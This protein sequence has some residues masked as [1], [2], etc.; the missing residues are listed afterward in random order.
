MISIVIPAYNY[1]QFLPEAIESVLSQG[2]EDIE[3]LISD[4]ASTDNTPDV[5]A[6]YSARYPCIRGERNPV[7]LGAVPNFN[8]AVAHA[9]GEYVLVLG[10]DDLLEP[11]ALAALKATLDAHP[12]CGYVY[13]RYNVLGED[14]RMLALQHAGW[15]ADS[16]F[17]TR[18]EFAELLCHDCYINIV[19]TLFRRS[20]LDTRPAFFD[21][22]LQSLP[23]ERFFRATDWD[24]SLDLS[25]RNVRSAF[26]NR[27]ISVFR[28]HKAQA[29]GHDRYAVSGVAITEHLV[30][31]ERY[32]TEANLAR[33]VGRLPRIFELAYGKFGFYAEHGRP[34]AAG[35][36]ADIRARFLAFCL[37]FNHLLALDPVSAAA[38]PAGLRSVLDAAMSSQPAAEGPT[39][40]SLVPAADQA[41]LF[42]VI[43]TTYN[44]PRL[45]QDALASVLDQSCQDFEILVVNDG[46]P[47]VEDSLGWTG[48]D[49]RITYIRQPN[50][51]PSAARN[52]ALRLARGRYVVYLDDDDLMRREHLDILRGQLAVTPDSVV[53]TSAE[54]VPEELRGGLRVE[55]KRYSPYQHED[56]DYNRLQVSNY[57]PINTFCHPRALLEKTGLFDETLHAL[58]D[59]DL[60][61]RFSR[62]CP[63]VH[64]RRTTV[65]VRQRPSDTS[66]HQTGRQIDT[67]HDLFRLIYDRYDDQGNITVRGGRAVVLAADHPSRARLG[68]FEYQ[69]W[70]DAH[71]LREVDVE[72][73][74]ERMISKWHRRPVF[75]LIVRAHREHMD[76]LG[77]TVQS[78]QQQFYTHWRL[79]VVADQPAP[80]PVFGSSDLLGWVQ[81]ESLE[82]DEQVAAA[83]NSVVTDRPGDWV[84]LLPPG[85][86]LSPECLLRLGDA[87]QGKDQLA[88]I[89]TDHDLVAMPGSYLDPWFKPDFNLEYLMSWDYIDAACFFNQQMIMNLGGFAAFPGKEGY[90]LLLRMADRYGESAISHLAYPMVHLPRQQETK[91]SLTAQRVAIEQHLVRIGRQGR[92]FDGAKPGLFKVEYPIAGQP[93]VSVIV[94]N[95]DRL[96]FLQPCLEGLLGRTAY[97]NL[98]VL[99]VDNQSTD[100]DVL[101]YYAALQQAYPDQIR[102]L[103]YDAPFNFSAQCN[104]GASQA[105]GEYLLFLNNDIEIVQP[106]W[107]ERLLMHAQRPEVG[108]VGAKLVYPET[109]KVQHGGI[110]LGNSNLLMGVANHFGM[111]CKLDDPGYMNR[112]QCDLYLSAVTAACMMMRKDVF[113]EAGG[114]N[115]ELKVLFNDVDFCLRV[116]QK[117]YKLLWTPYAILVHHHGISV[118]ARLSDPVEQGRF[119]ERSRQEH[120]YMYEHWLTQLAHDPAYN[121]NLA[122]RGMPLSYDSIVPCSWEPT[123]DDRP[124]IMGC[125]VQ[126]GSG[127]YRVLQPLIALAVAGKAQETSVHMEAS[128]NQFPSLLEIERTRPNVLVAQNAFNDVQIEALKYY[129]QYFPDM[130]RVLTLDDLLTDLPEK[131]SLYRHIKAHFRDGRRRL[132]AS[133]EHVDR[134]IV[135]TEPLAEC[136][137]EL[138]GDIH[139]IPN[140]LP[141]SKWWD[142][143]TLRRA[144]RKPRVG[145]VGAQQHKGDL[146]LLHEVVRAT[147]DEVEWVFMGMWPEGM[148]DCITEKRSWVSFSEYPR[149]M[150][151]LNLDLA[152][153][154]LEVNAFNESK[155]NLRLLEYGAMG[156]P[157]VCSDVLPYQSDNAPVKRVRNEPAAWIAAIR[158]RVHDLDAAEREGD[159]LRQWV[160]NR[161]LLEDNLDEWMQAYTR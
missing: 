54:Y 151:S 130:L 156:W 143:P 161:Y 83:F 76:K 8:R 91:L 94:P 40:T 55:G 35:V 84:A 16:Y 68:T 20:L 126:G 92:V 140:Y 90:E 14:G 114:F 112:M 25:L 56:F 42:S 115:E 48:E 62:L 18:D 71:G 85:A 10:A 144:G 58:E 160:G 110:V 111:D 22:T 127:E 3:I 129:K 141:K 24:L 135:T 133:L 82:N 124:R 105:R 45:L 100:P 80:S 138:I 69:F 121:R 67:L 49:A 103:S 147:A 19:A 34:A 36:E 46:G 50:R 125:A 6:D 95:R 52:A 21:P 158:E 150:A 32:L 44:R 57:I 12:E 41:P 128:G 104:L 146:E 88:A 73:L 9:R 119:A 2:I 136:A 118:N 75:N 27:Q 61:I 47:A 89:Y 122:L 117:G 131:S 139:I 152:V 72:I 87:L 13:G 15:A 96:E 153:A 66:Q 101:S 154:P 77:A 155:S 7:N 137:S 4:D 113:V 59:W 39:K 31:L 33:V 132:R 23:G 107:L 79:V 70:Q 60:L 148:D 29:S 108:M 102:V 17:G 99:V 142:L 37:R 11:G 1:G 157:V 159:L 74:A 97:R 30:L 86:E 106:E 51:G 65:E 81:V 145:W 63:F 78:L 28:Q 98:E 93:L 38:M 53:Y 5:I 109:G 134:L 64:I 123:F 43:M 26:L 116:G 149:A 120:A